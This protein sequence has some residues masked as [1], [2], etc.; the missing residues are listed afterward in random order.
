MGLTGLGSVRCPDASCRDEGATKIEKIEGDTRA[1]RFSC[2]GGRCIHGEQA[3]GEE[4]APDRRWREGSTTHRS[5]SLEVRAVEH[6][7]A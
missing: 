1:V 5:T 2:Q 4:Y 7:P 3:K 6:G